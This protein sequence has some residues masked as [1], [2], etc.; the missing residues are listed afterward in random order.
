MFFSSKPWKLAL[1][2]SFALVLLIGAVGRDYD[3][4]ARLGRLWPDVLKHFV[5][6]EN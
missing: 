5:P 1:A 2:L 4:T 3:S 6:D